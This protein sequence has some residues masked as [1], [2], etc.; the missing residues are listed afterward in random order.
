M[1]A[2]SVTS[3]GLALALG[4]ALDRAVLTPRGGPVPVA[5]LDPGPEPAAADT[6]RPGGPDA[7]SSSHA[8]RRGAS[9]RPSVTSSA[10]TADERAT[11][12][13]GPRRTPRAPATPAAPRVPAADAEAA[14]V[15]LTNRER[16]KAGCPALRVDPALRR[17]ARAHSADMAAHNY[18]GHDSRD[19]ESP[20][21]RIRR[22][23]NAAPGAENIARGFPTARAVVD[24]WMHSPG[25]R[26]NIL[27]CGLRSIGVGM[28]TG[29][30]GPWW[31]QDF[32][33]S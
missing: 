1:I 16:A 28:A 2:T 24:G 17:A 25:H 13:N 32:G 29:P 21:Q 22:A 19:G 30:G 6:V 8:A 7:A 11:R 27:N 14:A 10:G 23:G 26:A 20:W 12:P 9:A 4:V 5:V 33:W 15:V 3:A 31:T 18:F